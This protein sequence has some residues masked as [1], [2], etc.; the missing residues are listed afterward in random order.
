MLLQ[1]QSGVGTEQMLNNSIQSM[2]Y[3]V[4]NAIRKVTNLL[5]Q[6]VAFTEGHGEWNENQVADITRELK[7]SYLVER[8]KINEQLGALKGIH[9]LIIAGSDSMWS[10]K[11]KFI[12]DQY[13]MNGG[14]VLWL[15]DGTT[16]TM[17]SLQYAP[18]AIALANDVNLED[19]L[20]RYGVRINYNL[21]MDLQSAP[22]PV[23]TGVVGNRPQQSLLPWY[24]FP[25]IVPSSTHPLVKNLN[26]LKFEFV[27]SL[28]TVG[29]AGI[30]KTVL[31]STSKYSRE[32]NAPVRVDLDVMRR[33]PD[34]NDFNKSDLPVAVLLEGP[35]VSNYR[36]RVSP[37]ISLDSTIGFRSQGDTTRMVVIGDADVIRN[38]VRKSDGAIAPLGLDRYTGT[39]YGN[40]AF[41][42][43]C[44]DYL[45]D[46]SGLM[47]V[48]A[49][50]FKLRL[51]D[52][53]RLESELF[54][55]QL[56]NTIVPVLLVLI[57][58]VIKFILRRKKYAI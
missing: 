47:N 21:L 16:A 3:N 2:E 34:V 4:M 1:D 50:E 20:F 25:V 7:T 48:R 18:E 35:F 33:E 42:M 57:F 22:I 38:N 23:V 26:A 13:I 54:K 14:K 8:V 28:D 29:N 41:I 58:A 56:I 12:L 27:S 36:N 6:R 31:L 43:N 32:M 40:K 10:E 37:L 15:V 39:V 44:V 53:T 24:Y 17:D 30:K 46:D 51:L 9:A 52:K 5:P 45:F 49:K 19:M 55:W 11:D